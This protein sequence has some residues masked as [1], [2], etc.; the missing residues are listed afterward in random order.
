MRTQRIVGIINTACVAASDKCW[1]CLFVRCAY[2]CVCAL[3]NYWYEHR[4]KWFRTNKTL[5][6]PLPTTLSCCFVR[7][8]CMCK[9]NANC[10]RSGLW[11]FCPY[12]QHII[13]EWLH[14]RTLSTTPAHRSRCDEHKHN[15][16]INMPNTQEMVKTGRRY[17]VRDKLAYA[18][19]VL[20]G[21]HTWD[22]RMHTETPARHSQTM[23]TA[24]HKWTFTSLARNRSTGTRGTCRAS[25]SPHSPQPDLYMENYASI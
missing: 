3:R 18:L 15:V 16:E 10:R 6:T 23:H 25:F 12:S 22:T 14:I 8:V 21:R 11:Q 2:V 13:T 4:F 1:C 9:C 24:L 19:H 17:F 7:G 5:L 20:L